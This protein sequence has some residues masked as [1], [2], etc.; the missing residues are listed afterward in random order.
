M[1]K[2]LVADDEPAVREMIS[3]ACKLDGHA[4]VEAEDT[5][6]TIRAYIDGK[7]E[8]LI[9]DLLMPGGG[10]M[11]V[12]SRLRAMYGANVC[13][14]IVVSGHIELLGPG[15][16][17]SGRPL[18]VLEKPFSLDALRQAIRM[19]LLMGRAPA[20]GAPGKPA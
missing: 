1:A 10:G 17:A 7:P 6:K 19:C 11:E 8:V 4:V 3:L 5:P 9:L 13:P 14:V 20:A 16:G 18:L 15:A 12:L 2:I